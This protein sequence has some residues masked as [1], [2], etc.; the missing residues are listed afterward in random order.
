M[1]GRRVQEGGKG[2]AGSV[3]AEE[4]RQLRDLGLVRRQANETLAALQTTA[5][6]L[7]EVEGAAAAVERAKGGADDKVRVHLTT[8]LHC[9]VLS[10]STELPIAPLRCWQIQQRNSTAG[11][12]QA[13]A[14]IPALLVQK[15]WRYSC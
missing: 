14:S 4:A 8:A 12:V 5:D 3:A 7:D 9:T 11:H 1:A 15:C 6:A 10:T 2:G 13:T